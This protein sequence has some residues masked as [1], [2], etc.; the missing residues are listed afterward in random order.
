MLTL[1]NPQ[2]HARCLKSSEFLP[3]SA[4]SQFALRFTSVAVIKR[5]QI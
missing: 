3:Y 4:D 1:Y 2:T 5:D